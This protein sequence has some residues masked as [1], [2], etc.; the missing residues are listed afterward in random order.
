[1]IDILNQF[2]PISSK[3]ETYIL[4]EKINN[5]KTDQIRIQ[6]KEGD[7]EERRDGK[8][9]DNFRPCIILQMKNVK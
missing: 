6:I 9:D 4:L 5:M 1:M 2:C 7:T 3:N 8:K